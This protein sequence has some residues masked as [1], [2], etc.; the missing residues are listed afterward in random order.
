MRF[1][2][3]FPF[4]RA[5]KRWN[6]YNRK[7]DE[8]AVLIR[9]QPVPQQRLERPL[10]NRV[11]GL[12]V[13]ETGGN[14]DKAEVAKVVGARGALMQNVLDFELNNASS[15]VVNI[16]QSTPLGSTGGGGGGVVASRAPCLDDLLVCA[17]RGAR[18]EEVGDDG[19]HAALLDRLRA[20]ALRFESSHPELSSVVA[21]VIDSLTA[22]GI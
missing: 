2:Q 7:P 17:G 4:L 21:R 6:R 9:N 10:L 15:G 20:G 18:I 8:L 13:E 14:C 11:I 16:H 5:L 3:G 12:V 1:R 19:D 22:A